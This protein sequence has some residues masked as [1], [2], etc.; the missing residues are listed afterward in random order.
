MTELALL[1][2]ELIGQKLP[3]WHSRDEWKSIHREFRFKDFADAFGFMAVVAI[4]ADKQ[5]HHPEWS[6]VYNQVSITLTTH[7]AAGL[8]ARDVK[9]AECVDLA[10]GRFSAMQR[11]LSTSTDSKDTQ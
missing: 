7:D 1:S 5:D 2:P 6:N 10:Y 9:L 3:D 11:P 8:T 4:H